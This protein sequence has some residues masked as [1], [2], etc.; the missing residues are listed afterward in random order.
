MYENINKCYLVNCLEKKEYRRWG[1]N[2]RPPACEAGVIT[3]R[4]DLFYSKCPTL[5]DVFNMH[6]I[7]ET[8]IYLSIC[9]PII[10]KI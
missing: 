1:S 7:L 3:T 5:F 9:L 6:N 4:P 8:Y 10:L 2:P